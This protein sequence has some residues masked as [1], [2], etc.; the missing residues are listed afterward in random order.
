MGRQEGCSPQ[1]RIWT[2]TNGTDQCKRKGRYL[3]AFMLKVEHAQDS[4]TVRHFHHSYT[5]S[6]DNVKSQGDTPQSILT[7]LPTQ[8]NYLKLRLLMKPML[9]V[10]AKTLTK[11]NTKHINPHIPLHPPHS[12]CRPPTFSFP[13][14]AKV[15]VKSTSPAPSH[16]SSS[17]PSPPSHPR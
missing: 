10:R 5:Y 2:W 7:S 9:D 1:Y 8:F 15:K 14:S 6:A 16:T 4:Q 17:P 12:K 13:R 3:V 11:Q